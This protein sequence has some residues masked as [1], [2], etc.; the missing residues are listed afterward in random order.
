MKQIQKIVIIGPCTSVGQCVL[1][2]L[3]QQNIPIDLICLLDIHQESGKMIDYNTT[4][5]ITQ[6]L[7]TFN[8]KARHIIFVCDKK[9]IPLLQ[10]YKASSQNYWIDCTHSVKEAV[11]IIP[12]ING[13]LLKTTHPKWICNP[14]SSVIALTQILFPIL[15]TFNIQDIQLTM[16]MGTFFDGPEASE[17]LITQNRHFLTQLPLQNR[18]DPQLAFNLIPDY[19]YHLGLIMKRQ[20]GCF[21]TPPISVRT[22]FAPIIRGSCV[23]VQLRMKKNYNPARI[24]DKLN[25]ISGIQVIHSKPIGLNDI[26]TEN[27]VFVIHPTL[28]NHILSFWCLH[29][30][31]QQGIGSN[32]AG[33]AKLLLK[34]P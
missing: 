25:H 30:A 14:C 19:F 18:P 20:L 2:Q 11:C 22:C 27:N 17:I 16:I 24:L 15:K 4:F 8:F 13:D 23:H 28:E 29:D 10:R 6:P 3:A 9:I 33:L 1:G 21:L 5:L 31:L 34:V 7:D 32:A 12:N 26:I